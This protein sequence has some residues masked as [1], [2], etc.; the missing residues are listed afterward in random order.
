MYP[1]W[2]CT[3]VVLCVYAMLTQ[4]SRF[5]GTDLQSRL[6]L[7]NFSKGVRS[8]F[9]PLTIENGLQLGMISMMGSSHVCLTAEQ[10]VAGG[11]T[12]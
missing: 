10:A 12:V 5:Y 7:K 11:T 4:A 3:Y 8:F 2:A 9:C 6:Q 1:S